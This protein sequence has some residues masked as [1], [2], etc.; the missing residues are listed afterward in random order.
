MDTL[1]QEQIANNVAA[2][3]LSA[4]VPKT[5]AQN[6][7]E[8][9]LIYLSAHVQIKNMIQVLMIVPIVIL[10]VCIAMGQTETCAYHAQMIEIY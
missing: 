2:N 3:A 5:T 7:K 10:V 1:N 8:T 9:G 4:Q 6:A